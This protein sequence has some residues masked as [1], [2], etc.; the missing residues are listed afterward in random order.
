MKLLLV[1][2]P[3][4]NPGQIYQ[5]VRPLGY[6]IIKYD[7]ILKAMDN[8]GEVDPQA[9]MISARDFPR[10]WKTMVQFVRYERSK[11]TCPIIILCD[12][13]FPVEEASKAS[14]LG[15]NSFVTEALDDPAE[16]GKLGA[17]LSRYASPLERRRARRI[18]NKDRQTYGFVF[19]NPT[20][21]TLITG[22]V[23]D[24]SSGGISFLCDNPSSIGKLEPGA[25][26]EECSLRAGNSFY[27]P[28]CRLIR[29][30][31]SAAMEFLSF[32]ELERE[33]FNTQWEKISTLFPG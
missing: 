17:I 20:E 4:E 22:E 26:L 15:V 25:G 21:D 11:E 3:D 33:N 30:G 24:I 5:Y 16:A 1:L 12:K 8:V 23:R 2:G 6:E 29:T 27:S 28:A 14:W 9:I 32:P 7:H 13:S 19:I 10:H 31:R 18:L